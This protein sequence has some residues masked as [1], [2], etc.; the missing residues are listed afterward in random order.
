MWCVII[1]INDYVKFWLSF[2]ACLTW[3]KDYWHAEQER[4]PGP[5]HPL[6]GGQRGRRGRWW[7]WRQSHPG[8]VTITISFSWL[9]TINGKSV[10]YP[11]QFHR[12]E[13]DLTQNGSSPSTSILKSFAGAAASV[14]FSPGKSNRACK[15][16]T[17]P[18]QPQ[19]RKSENKKGVFSVSGRQPTVISSD[20]QRRRVLMCIWLNQVKLIKLWNFLKVLYH[21][22]R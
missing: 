7:K 6:G 8:R 1:L 21:D 16:S 11:L 4:L 20:Q 18:T 13:E 3:S 9:F 10:L 19:P 22:Q 5:V 15:K 14:K 12:F 2:S 17:L